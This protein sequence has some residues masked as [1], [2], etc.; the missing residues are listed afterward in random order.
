MRDALPVRLVECVGDRD[1][2]PQRLVERQRALLEPL[3]QGLAL[4]ILHDQVV[5]CLG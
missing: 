1:G 5:N 2:D 3:R 4:Q